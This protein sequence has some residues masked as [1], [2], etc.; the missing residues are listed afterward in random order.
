MVSEFI[1]GI[2]RTKNQY[3]EQLDHYQRSHLVLTHLPY[4]GSFIKLHI[5]LLFWE[6]QKRQKGTKGFFG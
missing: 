2:S 3:M 5:S 4:M 6:P 1:L